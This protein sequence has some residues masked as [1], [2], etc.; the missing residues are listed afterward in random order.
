MYPTYDGIAYDKS[1]TPKIWEAVGEKESDEQCGFYKK[2]AKLTTVKEVP[3]QNPNI[4][5]RMNF[6]ILCA[7]NLVLNDTFKNWAID[8]LMNKDQTKETAHAVS[9]KLTTQL[10]EDLPPDQEYYTCAY[11]VLAAVMLN[12][13]AEFCANA[14]HRA[15]F[16]AIDKNVPLNLEQLAQIAVTLTGPDIAKVF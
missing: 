13:P 6:A 10:S 2:Y 5:Q 15:Y 3:F 16:D 4:N 8:Y 9:E 14:A 1:V 12:E 7:M 11:P